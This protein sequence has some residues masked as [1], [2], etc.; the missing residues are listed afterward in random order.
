[1]N[2]LDANHRRQI[3]R[4]LGRSLTAAELSTAASVSELSAAQIDVVRALARQQLVSAL[5]YM[6]AIVPDAVTPVLV[7]YI[8]SCV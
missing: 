5:D 8:N 3:E 4:T 7:K 6:R 1:M 2:G